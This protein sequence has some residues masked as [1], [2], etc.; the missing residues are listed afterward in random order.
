MIKVIQDHRKCPS[1]INDDTKEQYLTAVPQKT[2][3][4][5]LRLLL[6]V[7]IDT[8]VNKGTGK[9]HNSRRK[10]NMCGQ[11]YNYQ[12]THSVFKYVTIMYTHY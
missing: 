3:G 10:R 9:G 2:T 8:N 4:G 7:I 1:D 6:Q 12:G 11:K 5:R